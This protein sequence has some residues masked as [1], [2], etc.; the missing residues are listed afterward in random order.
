MGS[1]FF[2]Y[3]RLKQKNF[4]YF[5]WFIEICVYLRHVF[6]QKLNNMSD[7]RIAVIEEV[8]YHFGSMLE[9]PEEA[10]A[11]A[12]EILDLYEMLAIMEYLGPHSDAYY[13]NFAM[14]AYHHSVSSV[15]G[16]MFID[17]V[18]RQFKGWKE[19]RGYK[20]GL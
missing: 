10:L 17:T 18:K 2:M 12:D 20:G 11:I 14:Q 1:L 13:L 6:N 5:V 3:F 19:S 16:E 15:R 8:E 4:R 7:L 9:T